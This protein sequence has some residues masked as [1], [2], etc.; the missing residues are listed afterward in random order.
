MVVSKYVLCSPS[1]IGGHNSKIWCFYIFQDGL[2]QPP[3]STHRIHRTGIFT[4]IYYKNQPNVGEYTIHGRYGYNSK[5]KIWTFSEDTAL[6]RPS[7]CQKKVP[8]WE[9]GRVVVRIFC[10]SLFFE[11]MVRWFNDLGFYNILQLVYVNISHTRWWFQNIFLFTPRK[12]SNWTC[13]H[14]SK[15]GHTQP[16]T[17]WRIIPVNKWLVAPIYKPW[18]AIWKGSHNPI[19]RGRSNDHHGY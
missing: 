18:M 8:R 15:M 14:F 5:R 10:R 7:E 6:F 11:E 17:T 19:L 4:Y 16:A 2:V 3:G 13:A 9:K 12:W 1:K